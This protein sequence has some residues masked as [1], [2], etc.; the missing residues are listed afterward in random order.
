MRVSVM[1]LVMT[2]LSFGATCVH[3]QVNQTPV[4]AVQLVR[5]VVY[6]E[7]HDHATHGYCRFRG[8]FTWSGTGAGSA[9][10]I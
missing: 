1:S 6:N 3:S 2:T 10:L 4:P 7:L 8:S 5:E 9:S